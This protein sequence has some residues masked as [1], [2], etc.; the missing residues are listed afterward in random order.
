MRIMYTT[1]FILL[2]T[3]VFDTVESEPFGHVAKRLA[4]LLEARQ[5]APASPRTTMALPARMCSSVIWKRTPRPRRIGRIFLGHT[6]RIEV[7]TRKRPALAAQ[8]PLM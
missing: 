7:G 4:C 3:I 1:Y 5:A 2:P 6:P 8:P